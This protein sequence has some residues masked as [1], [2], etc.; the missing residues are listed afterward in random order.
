MNLIYEGKTKDVYAAG[1]NEIEL[2]FKD[3]VTTANGIFDPGANETGIQ[4]EGIGQLNVAISQF[5][6]ERIAAKNIPLHYISADVEQASM[7]VKPATV[8]GKGIEVITRY[9]AWGSFIRRYGAYI[10]QATPLDE[11]MEITIKDDERGDPLITKDAL[12]ALD[13]MSTDEYEHLVKLQSQ[14]SQIVRDELAAKGL[15][16][17]DLKLE[18]GLDQE[19]NVMLIDEISTG[20]MR[21]RDAEGIVEPLEIARIILQ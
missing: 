13:I 11:Y 21:I 10:E 8:F 6:F 4:I 1:D 3:D 15:I 2:R 7:R 18:F 17:I 12:I 9:V 16:L 19:N 20:N 14:I 5:F